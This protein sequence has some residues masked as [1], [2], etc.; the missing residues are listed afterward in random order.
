MESAPN[1]PDLNEEKISSQFIESSFLT[2]TEYLKSN[3][4][5]YVWQKYKKNESWKVSTWSKR[6]TYQVI[7]KE[8]TEG[9]IKTYLKKQ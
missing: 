2:A 1:L 7:L 8:G 3:V 5:S 9:D 6:V 4:C